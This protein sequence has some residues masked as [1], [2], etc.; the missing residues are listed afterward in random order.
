[1]ILDIKKCKLKMGTTALH[2]VF[3]VIQITCFCLK[4][5]TPSAQDQVSQKE[6]CFHKVYNLS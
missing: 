2:P 3:I 1:V 5:K 4:K 6:E